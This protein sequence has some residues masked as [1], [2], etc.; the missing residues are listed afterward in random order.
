MEWDV[1]RGRNA[2]AYKEDF[3]NHTP[4]SAALEDVRST[5]PL[6]SKCARPHINTDSYGDS[7]LIV[8]ATSASLEGTIKTS[9]FS[10]ELLNY[11]ANGS[12]F[13]NASN[14]SSA[15]VENIV[16]PPSAGC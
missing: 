1:R 7:C 11:H 6:D 14:V 4:V 13:F 9:H 3:P 2:V 5:L 8:N 16:L 10:I 15:D 12:A